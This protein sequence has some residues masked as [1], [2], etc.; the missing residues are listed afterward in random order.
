M[1]DVNDQL[2]TGLVQFLDGLSPFD[3]DRARGVLLACATI[4]VDA[5]EPRFGN[6]FRTQA[7]VLVD[8][9]YVVLRGTVEAAPRAV[10]TRGRGPVRTHAERCGPGRVNRP[11]PNASLG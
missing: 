7:L 4:E 3:L 8:E 5:G 6:V 11:C 9:G 1:P 2:P 10:V